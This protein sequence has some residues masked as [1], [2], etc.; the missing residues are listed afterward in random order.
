MS[1]NAFYHLSTR[2][3]MFMNHNGDAVVFRDLDLDLQ[4]AWLT[5][6][7]RKV[8]DGNALMVSMMTGAQDNQDLY[9]R[10]RGLS[11]DQL[12]GA[13]NPLTREDRRAQDAPFETVEQVGETANNGPMFARRC[14]AVEGLLHASKTRLS[15]SF[16]LAKDLTMK[17]RPPM[18][19]IPIIYQHDDDDSL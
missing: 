15:F 4:V 18:K 6:M 1:E 9:A 8:E 7:T 11:M 14:P 16:E 13:Q 17:G 19:G 10:S 2:G 5:Y 12:L 3:A